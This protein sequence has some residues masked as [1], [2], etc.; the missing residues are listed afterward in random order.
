MI[1]TKKVNAMPYRGNLV[2]TSYLVVNKAMPVFSSVVSTN[3]VRLFS[4]TN[5][6]GVERLGTMMDGLIISDYELHEAHMRYIKDQ[7]DVNSGIKKLPLGKFT[8]S[9]EVKTKR[10]N[11]KRVFM[12]VIYFMQNGTRY[13]YMFSNAD[14]TDI[15]ERTKRASKSVRYPKWYQKVLLWINGLN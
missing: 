10:T 1:F 15:I 2:K 11:K 13:G 5:M 12:N 3:S 9:I 14:L 4:L 6:H 7:D 8:M